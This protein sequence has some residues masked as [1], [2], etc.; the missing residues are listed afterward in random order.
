MSETVPTSDDPT[1]VA[2][3]MAE[4][5]D[6]IR[7]LDVRYHAEG[8][9]DVPDADYDAMVRELRALE[10][11]HPE[12]VADD[13]PTAS[14][15]A[16]PIGAT[17]AP[18]EHRVPMMSLDNA[19]DADELRGW[20]ERLARS[21]EREDASDLEFI[22]ELKIDGIA[23]SL[24]YE[25]GVFVQAAT[26]GNGKVGEDVTANVATI[27]SIPERLD[28]APPVLE[29]RGEVYMP[30]STFEA[31]NEAQEAAGKPRYANP[32]NTTAGSLRQ[33]DP[34]IT[35][36]RG[37]DFWAY[38]LGEVVDGPDTPRQSDALDWLGELGF[39]VNPERRRIVGADALVGF[40]EQWTEHRHDLDYDIDGL[41]FK[42]D[43]LDLQRA[44]GST[45]KA[46]RWAIAS[47][48]P[49][50]ERTTTLLAIEVSVGRTGKA[51][52]FAVL[53]PV[54]V[55]GSTVQMATLHNDDQVRLKDVRPGDTV[56]VRKAGDV[57]PEVVGPVLAD[58]AADSEPWVFPS[59]CP[60]C[61]EPLVRPEGE[62]HTFC[63]NPFCPARQQAQIEYFASRGAMDIDGVGERTVALLIAEGLI[64][65]SGDLFHLDFEK[66]GEL[67]GYGQTS[68][69]NMRAGIDA[70]RG[71][72]L[73]SLLVGLGVRHLGPS[74][75][76]ALARAFGHL[77]AI[78]A[79]D[80][81]AMAA[82]DGVGPTIAGSVA[83]Y[84]DD[85]RAK[86]LIEKFRSGGVNLVG[87]E[88]SETEQT[89]AGMAVVVTGTLAGFS[90]D[91]AAD[92]IKSRG[93]KSPGS[94]SKKTAA[95]VVGESPGA[96]KLTKATDLGVPI[97][98]EAGFVS[99]LETGVVPGVPTEDA[100][101]DEAA[102]EGDAPADAG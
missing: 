66:V 33:K 72:P 51:T 57:I 2:A 64:V 59:D 55:G 63:V 91:E 87:P 18:V 102:P 7:R 34:T 17:F 31:L 90:R 32:R 68:V 56:I 93:G 73:A 76:E 65:D 81:E 75:A 35:A 5:A 60:T 36:S 94:V 12:L 16:A 44:L 47:K 84:F 6:E 96:S 62:A 77:D 39:P 1:R 67:E 13:S 69:D 99:L 88:V 20:A 10:A 50:E 48:L 24:R 58:R 37:L 78:M 25:D 80:V 101:S 40:V 42:I 74:G 11:E 38:Q 100:A 30:N 19:F 71:R 28:G 70:A 49:P 54:F 26:R 98:D 3:R 27:A 46:P 29:V 83:A 86:A 23:M 22:G 82:V 43:G 92:A 14:V 9:S 95:V 61:A 4:L 53:D 45:S 97:L 79:A 52:P 21:L 8:V 41:V 89:L 15:G 85:E